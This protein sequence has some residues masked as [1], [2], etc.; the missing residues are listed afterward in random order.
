MT[1]PWTHR[2][3]VKVDPREQIIGIYSLKVRYSSTK[4][5]VVA[6]HSTTRTHRHQL[7]EHNNRITFKKIAAVLDL[8]PAKNIG[9][10]RRGHI[11]SYLL[12]VRSRYRTGARTDL[13]RQ[14]GG[15]LFFDDARSTSVTTTPV[16]LVPRGRSTIQN[17][18]HLQY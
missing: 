1:Q 11:L 17:C 16:L 6:M 12:V 18:T 5:S 10:P 13:W 15:A 14:L 9:D 2:I 8:A 7:L 4:Y 3:Y